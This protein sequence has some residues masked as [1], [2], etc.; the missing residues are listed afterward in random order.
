[1]S[2]LRVV[3]DSNLL[4]SALLFEWPTVRELMRVLAYPKFHRSTVELEHL[5]RL[6]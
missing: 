5:D 2:G 6:R 4:V 3:L 1:V